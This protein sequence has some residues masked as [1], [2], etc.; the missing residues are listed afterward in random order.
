MNVVCFFSTIHIENYVVDVCVDDTTPQD[1]SEHNTA[2]KSLI[3]SSRSWS[4]SL[5]VGHTLEVE[6]L[7]GNL[8][9]LNG[10]W[11]CQVD[12]CSIPCCITESRYW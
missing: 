12:C 11:P 9:K 4:E 7:V 6:C 10:E 5:D 2:Y 3:R 8:S 1:A